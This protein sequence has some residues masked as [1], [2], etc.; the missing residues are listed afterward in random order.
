MN[1]LS[2]VRGDG[3]LLRAWLDHYVGLG[4]TAFH[5]IVHGPRTDNAELYRLAATYPMH[6]REE[7]ES[8]F[9]AKEKADRMNRALRTLPPEWM[10]LVDSD[11]FVELP[12]R[13]TAST[14]RALDRLGATALYAPF[15]NRLREDGSLET[16]DVIAD[17]FQTLPLCAPDLHRTMGVG[18]ASEAKYP[19]FRNSPRTRVDGGNHSLPNRDGVV[20]TVFRGVTHH[21]KWRRSVLQRLASRANSA[22]SY[23]HESVGF[24]AYLA[25]HGNRFPTEGTFRYSRDELFRRRLLAR[26]GP[27]DYA[28]IA[29]ARVNPLLP[30]GIRHGLR[31]AIACA[32][33]VRRLR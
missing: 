17:P 12:Y 21:F 25:A 15:L 4:V 2:H 19:L 7:Y 28:R 32:N 11:E 6:I 29:W 33:S 3:D 14:I 8:E 9:S 18:S 31:R 27:S 16:P 20:L 10:F 30:E 5:L 22:H 23:R 1:L 24:L 26:A 13:D